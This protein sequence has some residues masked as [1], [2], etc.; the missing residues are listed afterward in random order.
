MGDR[1]GT[2]ETLWNLSMALDQL[3]ARA[4]AIECAEAAL[5]IREEL[6][7]PRA[8][9]IRR[10]LAKWRGSEDRSWKVT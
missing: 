4:R 10:Q 5:R 6:E 1:Q 8:D 7:D 9:R 3:G 2:A